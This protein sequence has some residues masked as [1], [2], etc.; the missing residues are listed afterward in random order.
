MV[1]MRIDIS[2]LKSE[3][4]DLIKELVEL[5]EERIKVE[6]ETATDEII[7]K[8]EEEAISRRYLRVLLRKFLHRTE[9]KDYFRVI[10]GGENTWVV[11]EKKIVEE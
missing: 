2:E 3:G 11:K 4:S 8:S 10:S 6:V 7:L 5:L 1:E 9:L